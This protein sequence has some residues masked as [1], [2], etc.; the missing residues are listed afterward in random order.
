MV[1]LVGGLW[2]FWCLWCVVVLT[3]PT[4]IELF[5]KNYPIYNL[6][7]FVFP[8]MQFDFDFFFSRAMAFWQSSLFLFSNTAEPLF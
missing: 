8:Y 1:V 3:P 6:Y 4:T 7:Y 2:V 5:Y